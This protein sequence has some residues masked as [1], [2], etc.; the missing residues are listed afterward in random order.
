ELARKLFGVS[1]RTEVPL[2]LGLIEAGDQRPFQARKGLAHE[3][4]DVLF[5]SADLHR[6]VGEQTP[7]YGSLG[8]RAL[9][10]DVE[11]ESPDGQPSPSPPR[12]PVEL[13]AAP[14]T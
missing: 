2:P 10:R 8:A 1:V 11:Q 14:R 7:V 13:C 9:I 6:G 5:T 12:Q 3:F 4:G